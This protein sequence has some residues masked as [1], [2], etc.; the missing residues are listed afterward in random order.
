MECHMRSH[1]MMGTV[2][3]AGASLL[4]AQP[5]RETM[6]DR[7]ARLIRQLGHDDFAK[8]EAA[9]KEL[10]AIGEPALDALRKASAS[11]GDA[12]IR[13]RAERIVESVTGRIRAAAAKK[14]LAR[15]EGEWVGNGQQT[16]IFKGDRWAW[17]EPGKIDEVNGNR[18]VIVDLGEKAILADLLVGDPAKDGKVCKAIFRR[19]GDTLHYCG[20]Y[21][22]FYP[23]EFRTDAN[24]FYVAW[25]RVKPMR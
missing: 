15:W 12:E 4:H 5:D 6:T 19:D 16:L 23:T 1:V 7:V 24:T 18:I 8:R 3:L 11:D 10:D 20:T 22:G 21:A 13:R 2:L 17:G 9:S 25:K 14:E